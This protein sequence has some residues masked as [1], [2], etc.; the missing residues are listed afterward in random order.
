MTYAITFDMD[1][2]CLEENY[3]GNSV[4]NAYND[5]RTVLTK[6][7]FERQQGSVYFGVG[8]KTSVDCILAV[9]DL[10]TQYDWF[11]P[12]VNDIRM[13]RIEELNDLKPAIDKALELKNH[14]R[15]Y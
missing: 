3:H 8:E 13:L 11:A 2:H 1:T 12:C 5:I 14:G 15:N 4:N 6:H 9:Q 10:T 7:G